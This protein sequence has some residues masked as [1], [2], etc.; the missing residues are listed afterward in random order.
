M[1]QLLAG[2]TEVPPYS[3]TVRGGRSPLSWESNAPQMVDMGSDVWEYTTLMLYAGDCAAGTASE[4][5][6]WKFNFMGTVWEPLAG[7]RVHTLDLANGASDLIDVWWN[8]EDPTQFTTHDIDV[9]FF[10]DMSMSAWVAGDTVSINGDV[11]PLTYDVPSL[12]DLVDDG[13]G[14][15]AVA[16][17]MI[18]STL[19][20]FPAGSHNNVEYKF[21]LNGEYEC[22]GQGNRTVFLNSEMYDTVGGTLGPLTLPHR[23]L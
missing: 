7:N 21:L 22:A 8:D 20:T 3:F 17:D 19:V 14:N 12:I 2:T 16:G 13:T 10:V 11:L 4:S 6:E 18:F 5:F 15:D 23:D 1:G 9:E